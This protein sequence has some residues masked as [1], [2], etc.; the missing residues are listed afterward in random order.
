MAARDFDRSRA[1]AA[2]IRDDDAPPAPRAGRGAPAA[3]GPSGA[4]FTAALVLLTLCG[5]ATGAG[6]GVTLGE[7]RLPEPEA[8]TLA[9]A[10]PRFGEG[11]SLV[12]MNPV[13]ANLREPAETWVRVDAALVLED[14]PPEEA[15]ALA[16]EV[17]GDTL[18]Y[19][20]TLP[21]A[22]L[23]GASGLAYLREDLSERAR[24]RSDGR[25]REFVIETLVVQ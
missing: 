13:V 4:M 3:S 18:A 21:L 5:V 23:E 1:L 20:R 7:I 9:G 11:V 16:A 19:L 8:A 12:R 24:T 17:A 22:R 6:L 10:E 15:G 14:V 2:P 25:V